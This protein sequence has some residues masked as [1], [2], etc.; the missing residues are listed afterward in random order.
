MITIPK[1]VR[2]RMFL[3]PGQKTAFISTLDGVL[4]VPV[5]GREE[6]AGMARGAD[7]N[8]YRDRSDRY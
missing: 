3:R 5:P 8:R 4:I 2:E 6:I 1:S 7:P